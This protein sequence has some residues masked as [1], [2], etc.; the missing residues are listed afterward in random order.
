MDVTRVVEDGRARLVERPG[1]VVVTI[2]AVFLLLDLGR[3]L[4]TGSLPISQLLTFLWDGTVTGLALGVAGIGLS[5][6]YS[7]LGFANFGHGDYLTTGAFAGWSTSFLVAGLGSSG[8]G[9]LLLIGPVS[10]RPP[11]PRGLGIN[12]VD[13]PLAVVAGLIVAV[14]VTLLVTFVVDRLVYRPMRDDGA[15]SLLIASIGVA[16]AIRHLILFVYGGS[17]RGLTAGTPN[18]IFGGVDGRFT[19]I[20][21]EA[22]DLGRANEGTLPE[23]RTVVDLPIQ[24]GDYSSELLS[25]TVHE[26]TIVVAS[27]GMML[28]VH[29]LLQRTKLGTSMR[30]M[31]DNRSLAR[32]TG[33]PVE[34]VI[35][36]AWLLGGGLAG[37]AGYLI[38]LERGGTLTPN[39]GWFLLLLIFAAVI[40]GGIGSVYGAMAGGIIIG[41]ASRLALVWVPSDFGTVAAFG[42]M[43]LMLLFRPDGLF[44]GVT[45]A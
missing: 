28:G 6:T 34:R 10:G 22:G 11:T 20:V 41:I 42:I 17:S 43:I 16:L 7:I 26:V 23:G 8:I 31:A 1:S 25:V 45:T 24:F 21:G 18:V 3:Q 36:D 5:M 12:I 15:I 27:L 44:G 40:L 38:A 30:A 19:A 2:V 14:A 29:L 32:V 13:T 37:A 33:I 4:V 35:R 9:S 39:L